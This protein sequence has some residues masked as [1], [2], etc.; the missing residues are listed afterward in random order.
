MKE[1]AGAG[2]EGAL[3]CAVLLLSVLLLA[4]KNTVLRQKQQSTNLS[5]L[6]QPTLQH[7]FTDVKADA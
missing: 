4:P 1:G 5:P 7:R 3:L 6:F 2:S